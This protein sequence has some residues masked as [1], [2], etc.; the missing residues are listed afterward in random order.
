MFLTLQS[1][2][3]YNR[4]QLAILRKKTRDILKAVVEEV[5]RLIEQYP[6][7]EKKACTKEISPGVILR[8]PFK[9]STGDVCRM[10]KNENA[11]AFAAISND[12]ISDDILNHVFATLSEAQMMRF[13]DDL[14]EDKDFALHREISSWLKAMNR[15][16]SD[17]SGNWDALDEHKKYSVCTNLIGI[18]TSALKY[19]LNAAPA[20][21]L[22][23]RRSVSPWGGN[24]L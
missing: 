22:H 6:E 18:V 3:A 10:I 1:R 5:D 7:E 2:V 21:N 8:R 11:L 20:I 16:V 17:A 24:D 15:V 13:I 14:M 12:N 19:T 4:D 9:L 23:P